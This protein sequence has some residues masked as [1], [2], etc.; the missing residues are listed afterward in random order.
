MG[1]TNING[2]ADKADTLMDAAYMGIQVRLFGKS[3]R[4]VGPGTDN[5]FAR[6]QAL[7]VMYSFDMLIKILPSI[8]S[9]PAKHAIYMGLL[10][11]RLEKGKCRKAWSFWGTIAFQVLRALVTPEAELPMITVL[12]TFQRASTIKASAT[13]IGRRILFMVAEECG[14][15]KV[16]R[17]DVSLQGLVLS[18]ALIARRIVPTTEPLLALVYQLMTAQACGGKETLPAVGRWARMCPL[19]G[20][21]TLDVL[22]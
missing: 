10:Q 2:A 8:A 6:S 13:W 11:V 20:M 14:D 3:L 5:V 12:M 4:A 1:A 9:G 17:A 16:V 21:G 22:F 15:M 19:T 18:E 7:F